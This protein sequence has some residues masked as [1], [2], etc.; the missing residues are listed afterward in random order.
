MSDIARHLPLSNGPRRDEASITSDRRED[1]AI[2]CERAAALARP[3]DAERFAASVRI[4]VP[5]SGN[6]TDRLLAAAALVRAGR[7]RAVRQLA[8][9]VRALIDLAGSRPLELPDALTGRVALYAATRT[10]FDRRAAIAGHTVRAAD[11]DW[12]FGH[13]P[14]IEADAAQIVAFLLGTSDLPPRSVGA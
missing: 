11:A 2:V 3:G 4:E 13:G 9:A 7:K 14:V 5:P 1:L 6:D 12:Q 10:S 8:A